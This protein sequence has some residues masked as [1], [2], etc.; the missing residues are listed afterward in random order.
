MKLKSLTIIILTLLVLLIKPDSLLSQDVEIETLV[1][2]IDSL[3]KAESIFRFGLSVGPRIVLENKDILKRRNASISPVDSTLQFDNVDKFEMALA[4]VIAAY[5]FTKKEKKYL[6]NIG[7]IAKLNLVEFG[8]DS[9]VQNKVIEGGFG[10]TYSLGNE[11]AVSFTIERVT[12]E[13][14]RSNFSENEKIFSGRARDDVVLDLDPT[15]DNIFVDDNFTAL[16]L[17]WVYSF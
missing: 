9:F 4:G 12:G 8:P 5:P 17:S 7:F 10:L 15:D 11:F 14:V 13:R 1:G 2:R 16:S 6:K 3:K